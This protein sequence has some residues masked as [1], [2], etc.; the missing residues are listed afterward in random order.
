[1]YTYKLI[2][3][4]NVIVDERKISIETEKFTILDLLNN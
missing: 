1:M 3:S 4:E 2:P